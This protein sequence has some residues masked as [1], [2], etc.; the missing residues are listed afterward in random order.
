LAIEIALTPE[1]EARLIQMAEQEGKTPSQ[2]VMDTL[3]HQFQADEYFRERVRL[4]IKEAD[5]GNFIE[6]EE[7]DARFEKMI[8]G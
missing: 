2:L 6:E 8:R 4:G 3:T 1:Q 7:M 5:A